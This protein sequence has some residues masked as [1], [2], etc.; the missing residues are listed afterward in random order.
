MA[1]TG[2]ATGWVTNLRTGTEA[3]TFGLANAR[4]AILA[5]VPEGSTLVLDGH[6]QGGMIAQMLAA[7]PE[8]KAKHKVQ[9]TVAFGSLPIAIGA[10]EG[11]SR[12]ITTL[13]D[14]VP[15][16]SARAAGGLFVSGMLGVPQYA[17]NMKAT[18]VPSGVGSPINLHNNDYSNELNS[19]MKQIDAL[20]QRNS[21]DPANIEFD[22]AKRAFFTS[23]AP[24][25]TSRFLMERRSG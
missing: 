15:F 23:P 20:G 13:L 8:I 6:S 25:K 16:A 5:S 11:D 19:G 9:Q 1:K 7:D 2:Q 21:N 12:R 17:N 3:E 22:P 24:L 14:P 4:A 18:V 10:Q